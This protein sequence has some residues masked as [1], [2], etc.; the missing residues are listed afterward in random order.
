MSPLEFDGDVPAVFSEAQRCMYVSRTGD[1]VVQGV[2]AM[3]YLVARRKKAPSA[4]ADSAF[5]LRGS[6]LASLRPMSDLGFHPTAVLR[7]GLKEEYSGFS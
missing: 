7:S 4:F 6:Q 5:F 3:V 1:V 2:M